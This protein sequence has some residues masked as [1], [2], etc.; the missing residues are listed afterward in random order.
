MS[1]FRDLSRQANIGGGMLGVRV[2]WGGGGGVGGVTWGGS[3]KTEPPFGLG[4]TP[5]LTA[6]HNHPVVFTG[7]IQQHKGFYHTN[8]PQKT[9]KKEWRETGGG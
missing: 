9:F 7:S 1:R 4:N 8:G 3:L 5:G 6:P 2:H